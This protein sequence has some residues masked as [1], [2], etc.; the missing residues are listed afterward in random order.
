MKSANIAVFNSSGHWS[1]G[2]LDPVKPPHKENVKKKKIDLTSLLG[3]SLARAGAEQAPLTTRHTNYSS[4]SRLTTSSFGGADGALG[5]I[6]P[7][8]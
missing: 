6:D 1:F 4:T 5:A 7:F 2:A 8:G 3:I